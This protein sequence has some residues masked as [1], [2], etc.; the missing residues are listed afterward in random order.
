M[1]IYRCK[2]CGK[3]IL[4]LNNT[5]TPTICCNQEMECLKPKV[6]DPNIGEKHLPKVSIVCDRVCVRIGEEPHPHT[7]EHYIEWILLETKMGYQLRYLKPDDEPNVTFKVFEGC[8][9]I[10]VYAYCNIHGLWKKELDCC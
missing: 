10:A 9:P 3:I 4:I 1:K 2:V 5:G 6:E 8:K 7:G